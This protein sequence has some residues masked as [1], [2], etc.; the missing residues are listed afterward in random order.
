MKYDKHMGFIKNS[1]QDKVFKHRGKRRK[2]KKAAKGI[3]KEIVSI[4]YCTVKGL[5]I[6]S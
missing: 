3:P 6:S 5:S 2:N 4:L 1:W